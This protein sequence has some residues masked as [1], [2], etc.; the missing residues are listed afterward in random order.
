MTFPTPHEV[1]L[2]IWS[3]G[4]ED[5]HGNAVDVYTPPLG[6]AGAPHS[7]I[8][9]SVPTST[10]PAIAGHDRVI[11]DVELLTP[12]DFP[13][14]ARDVID[15]PYGPAG[16]FEVIGEVGDTEGNPFGWAPG[17]TLH[18]RRVEG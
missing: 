17:G 18:L 14:R 13:A 7:V 6:A 15:L 16:R 3:A 12:P 5:A 2:H 1:G 9:W 11:V 10:E 8:G 4:A